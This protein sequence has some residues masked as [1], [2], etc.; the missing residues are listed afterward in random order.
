L[1][2]SFPNARLNNNVIEGLSNEKVTSADASYI[3]RAPKLKARLT[4][5]YSK[6][7]NATESSFFFADGV[8]IDDGDPNT[9]DATSNFV[10]ETVTGINK[11]NIG[12]ELGI[13]YQITSTIKLTA[14]A[15]YGQY[16][17]DNNPTV[18][19]SKD[20]IASQTNQNPITDFGTAKLKG[21]KL[22][23]MPQEAY[24][25]GIEYRDPH[26]WWIG[27][28]ANYLA[29]NYI[30][31]APLT[32]TDNFFRNPTDPFNLPFTDINDDRARELLKQEKFD[33]FYL[34]NLTGGKSWR[35]KN[36]TIG[37]FAS[38][39]NVFDVTYKTGGFEQARN[40]NYKELNQDVSSGTPAF[41]PKYFYG[42][43][44]TY[45]VN[46]YVNF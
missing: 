46:L 34:V 36:T 20:A 42:F 27:A 38:I 10:A 14:S 37:T 25:L 44:R 9:D 30:D 45:F 5:Y 3:I 2:N 7:Q 31:V 4:G 41:A 28:N 6:V 17:Y 1:R 15:A 39:N 35:I 29:S 40:A 33:N 11:K 19:L 8:A 43:G 12:G 22:P 26:F 13:E 23:G 24:S 16:T 21:Y 32:R 18:T